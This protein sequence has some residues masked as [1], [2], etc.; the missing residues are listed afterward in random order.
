[1]RDEAR[2]T[3]SHQSSLGWPSGDAKLR[4]RPVTFVSAGVIEPLKDERSADE[5]SDPIVV[6]ESPEDVIDAVVTASSEVDNSGKDTE[7]I[8]LI[9]LETAIQTVEEETVITEISVQEHLIGTTET[10]ESQGSDSKELFFFDLGDDQ[11]MAD[12]PIPPPKIPSPRS[13]FAGSDSSEEVILFRGRTANAQGPARRHEASL[14]SVITAPSKVSGGSKHEATGVT[15]NKPVARKS[16]SPSQF[17]R[18]RSK[19][20]R[21]RSRAPK[22]TKDEEEDAILADYIANMAADSDDD[23]VGRLQAFSGQR[24]L[25]G[26]E[27]A[28]NFGSGDEKSPRGDDWLGNGGVESVKSGSSDAEEEDFR[29]GDNEDMDAEMDDEAIA[30]LL[31][32]QEELGMGGDDLLLFT[33]S[34]AQTGSRKAQGKRPA[35]ATYCPASATQVADAFDNLDLADWSHLTGQTRKRRSKQ[36]PNFNVSDSEIEAALKTAWSRDRERKKNRKLEREALRAEGL[37][38]KNANPDDL[39]VKYPSGMKLDDMKAELTAFLLSSA[40]R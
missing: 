5:P 36:P 9:Q 19:S 29:S 27:G 38:G 12:L 24:D 11:P 35:K 18:K 15:S 40:E 13:S 25:G 37:L 32:K 23:F 7:T 28:V 26:D 14:P 21:N 39:R 3:A 34:F 2:N 8:D 10:A 30:R 17:C 20:R 16:T 4:Q 33:S 1:M 22:S 31:A 6:E